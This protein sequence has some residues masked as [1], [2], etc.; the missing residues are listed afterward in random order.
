MTTQ[1][2]AR[3][4]LKE[5]L[6]RYL[7]LEFAGWAGQLG[8]AGLAYLWTGSL[9]AAAAAA[10]V[11]S[12]LGYYLPAYIRALRWA[13]SVERHRPWPARTVVIHVLALRS[14]AVEF[15]PAEAVDSLLVRPMLMYATPL[16]LNNIVLGWVVGG[17]VA[18]V[19]F[20]V[21]AIC[22]YEQFK[23]MLAVRRPLVKELESEPV[24][25]IAIA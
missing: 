22:S 2:R 7:P 13:A 5:W 8:A 20:Y 14:L 6:R 23:G 21:F 19:L 25:A 18:D 4:K 12:S 9:A 1:G 24:A 17:F 3:R 15:G 11:G 16:M 10:T